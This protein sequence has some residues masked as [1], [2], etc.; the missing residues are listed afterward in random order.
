MRFFIVTTPGL[1]TAT[2]KE[3]EFLS[4]PEQPFGSL[5]EQVNLYMKP[6]FGG[7]DVELAL[8]GKPSVT[9][10]DSEE[11][12][13]SLSRRFLYLCNLWLRTASRVLQTAMSFEAQSSDELYKRAIRFPWEQLIPPEKTFVIDT[14]KIGLGAVN[15]HFLSQK[16]KDAVVDRVR[17]KTKGQRPSVKR[18]GA[19]IRVHLHFLGHRATLSLDSSGDSLNRRGYRDWAEAPIRE[20]AAAALL[21]L[22]GYEPGSDRPLMDPMCGSG[23]FLWEAQLM[24]Q[25]R[26]PGLFRLENSH[27]DQNIFCFQNWPGYDAALWR[28]IVSDAQKRIRRGRAPLGFD[29]RP[30]FDLDLHDAQFKIQKQDFFRLEGDQLKNSM[31]ADPLLVMNPPFGERIAVKE[32]LEEFYSKLGSHLKHHFTGWRAGVLMGDATMTKHIGLKPSQKFK[33]NHGGL[34]GQFLIFDLYSGSRKTKLSPEENAKIV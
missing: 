33:F 19:D 27:S 15:T 20:S 11:L 6:G 32:S 13:N 28:E 2:I 22:L 14:T 31:G 12:V 34:D 8:K 5:A 1:E 26:A 3:I 9:D 24:A 18:S 21:F 4:R 10:P 17:Q 25:N 29:I 30:P 7:V 23:T 16:L